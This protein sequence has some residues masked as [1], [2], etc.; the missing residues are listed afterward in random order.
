MRAVIHVGMSNEKRKN[1]IPSA[2]PAEYGNDIFERK[3]F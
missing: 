1:E 3:A 2:P